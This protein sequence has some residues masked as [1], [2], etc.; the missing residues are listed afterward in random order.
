MGGDT[1]DKYYYDTEVRELL[2][3]E[4]AL[5]RIED[6]D[7][8]VRHIGSLLLDA[9]FPFTATPVDHK[10]NEQHWT[11]EGLV[12]VGRWALRALQMVQVEEV[13]NRSQ[14]TRTHLERL[15][16]LDLG[17]SRYWF[18]RHFSTMWQ[19]REA[20]GIHAGHAIG[21]YSGWTRNDYIAH[22]YRLSGTPMRRLREEDFDKAHQ[23]GEG[24][25]STYVTHYLDG[26]ISYLNETLGFPDIKSWE[27][28]DF[29]HWG[30]RVLEAN[31]G[32]INKYVIDELSKRDRGPSTTTVSHK[33]DQGLREFKREA[34]AA[35]HAKLAREAEN[36]QA[37]L[38][39]FGELFE[40]GEFPLDLAEADES[41]QIETTAKYWL[42]RISLP[43]KGSTVWAK[44]A[45]ASTQALISTIRSYDRRNLELT[46]GYIELLSSTLEV[47]DIIWPLREYMTYLRVP[48]EVLTRGSREAKIR[49][50]QIQ[51]ERANN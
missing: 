3:D 26:G 5:K 14:L 33:F 32:V 8:A 46:P 7:A 11:R 39:D 30:V 29:V 44:A 47:F 12:Q 1:Y 50:E 25:A 49:W 28:D 24:P 2:D 16:A 15:R 19:Y 13:N 27:K 40:Q 10:T 37:L 17:P 18:K 42:A 48:D 23:A 9:E 34:K 6:G 51:A 4:T 41:T 22:A 20:I 38:R 21:R 45:Q 36:R 31:N 43:K 35:W